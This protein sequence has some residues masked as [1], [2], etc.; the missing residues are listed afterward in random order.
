MKIVCLR[1]KKKLTLP[2]VALK[3]KFAARSSAVRR[4][5]TSINDSPV[6][7]LAHHHFSSYCKRIQRTMYNVNDIII[8]TRTTYDFL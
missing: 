7:F 6:Q 2:N 5:R 3:V 8:V 1:T 4:D